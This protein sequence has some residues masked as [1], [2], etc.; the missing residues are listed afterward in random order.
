MNCKSLTPLVWVI[1]L[2][3]Q[4]QHKIENAK[5]DQ[6]FESDS[7][8]QKYTSF[9]LTTDLTV[10]SENQKKMIPILIDVA[11]IMDDLFWNEAFGNK[12]TLLQEITDPVDQRFAEINYGPWDRLD[13]NKPFLPN[14]G[15]KPPGA[16]FY[17][18][19][20][21]KDEFE[22]AQL[23]DKRSLYTLIR[24]GEDGKLITVPYRE[25]F[26]DQVARASE[27]L[28]RAATLAENQ[29]FR[30][31]L[32]LRAEAFLTDEYRASDLAWMDSKTN[33][34]EFVVGPIENYEDNLYNYKAAHEAYILVKDLNWSRRLTK[35]AALLP[36]LQKG[37]PVAP[38]YK[39][40][41]PGTNA[42]LNAY[43][44]IYYAGDCNA[45]PKAIAINLPNDET[46]QLEKGTRRLQLKNAMQ[47]K[48]EKILVPIAN[49]VIDRDQRDRINFDAFFTN[50]MFHEVA[51][52]LGIKSTINGAST[53]RKALKEH[54]SALEEGKA[55]ILGL[56]MI[57]QLHAQN[58][59]DGN[60][61]DYYTT[62]M[63]GIFRSIR[64]GT[65]SAHG[66][67][68]MIRF[69]F[70]QEYGA[71]ERDRVAG[72]Y[73]VNYDRMQAAMNALSQKILILQ[74]DGDYEGA[75]Q[76]VENRAVIGSQL[77][78]DL[79]RL[80]QAGIPVD[81]EF[82]QGLEMLGL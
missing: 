16:N 74:G 56:Y 65:A 26:K 54:S 59:I 36:E 3:C 71:F 69:N 9:K 6:S 49:E 5:T 39:A 80:N 47:A 68:N 52:G 48:F 15:A 53:V 21:T 60:L 31:Y 35:Y 19:D 23:E 18:Q 79:E 46:V 14:F 63:A 8:L 73:R 12:Q 51:H 38:E 22:R 7:K 41:T 44:V 29:E 28:K 45:G 75:H 20:M 76:L 57:T 37:L 32:E 62:F 64:F 50:T 70:F 77:G 55:D 24:R 27:L 10:L 2:G 72:T 33:V 66:K 13:G 34:I 17:P 40:E 25:A 58:E 4:P 81:I 82:E 43:D 1:L 30:K 61:K 67:A 11:Q 78:N 42:D